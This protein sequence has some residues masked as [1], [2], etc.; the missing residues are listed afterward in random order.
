MQLGRIGRSRWTRNLAVGTVVACA[1]L[2][3]MASAA[4][5]NGSKASYTVNLSPATAPAGQSTTFDVA[6][7]N[8]SSAGIQLGSAAITPP[9]GFRVTHAS[10]PAGA[11]HAYVLFNIVVLDRL[12]LAPGAT[13]DV[14]VTATAPSRCNSPFKLWLSVANAGGLFG[15]LLRLDVANSSLTTPVTCDPATAVQFA[16]Q[17]NNALVNTDITGSS[18]DTSGGPVTVDLVD[19]GGNTVDSSAPVTLALVNP[20]G[21]NG[22]L[23]GTTTVNASH[24]VATFTD[25]KI[26]DPNNG[27]T[28]TAASGAL[29]SAP[30]NSFD[31][32]TGETDCNTTEDCLLTLTGAEST[33]AID[34]GP[35]GG[36]L[37]GQVDPGTPL[38][39]PG[40]SPTADPGCAGYNPQN[41]DWYGFDVSTVPGTT[42][43]GPAKTV[44]GTFKNATPDGYKICF[45]SSSEFIVLN[46]DGRPVDAQ[47]G[48][49]SDG[50]PGFVGFLP[51]CDTFD[52]DVSEPCITDDPLNT[53]EDPNST[54]GE[55]VIV[56]VSIPAGFPGDPMFGRG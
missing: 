45:G 23:G 50:T 16:G 11:G 39:G 18:Y 51:F 30:S 49:L 20:Q 43:G 26:D 12:S 32:S 5:A 55:D 15:Q 40:S 28:L 54:T 3:T 19:A 25:L 6:L 33:L 48:T 36:Q 7:K 42:A 35:N 4:L 41:L 31:T 13:V 47:A 9:L 56:S 27:Y 52:T 10:L 29:T 8:T 53:Q 17:P 21:G 46:S 1:A 2:A 34:A 38:D 24:G 44:T 37:N 14:S 22:T